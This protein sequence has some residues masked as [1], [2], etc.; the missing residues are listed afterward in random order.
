MQIRTANFVIIPIL[1]CSFAGCVSLKK[2]KESELSNKRLTSQVRELNANQERLT[3]E[4][5]AQKDRISQL[6]RSAARLRHDSASLGSE[7][8]GLKADLAD[9]N[10]LYADLMAQNK[11]LLENTSR[12]KEKLSLEIN[13]KQ[14][15]LNQKT[16][17][18]RAKE[19]ELMAKELALR[20]KSARVEELENMIRRQDSMVQALKTGITNALIGFKGDELSIELRNGK[21]Y[22]SL[23]DQLLFASGSI[24]VS[25][26][27]ED[28]LRKLAGALVSH[29]D[30]EVLIEGH[31]DN[32]PIQTD[33]MKDNWDLSV[34]RATSIVRILTGGGVRPEQI[35]AAGKGEH[36]PVSA[37]ESEDGRRLNR[38]TEI[39]LSPDLQALFNLLE[40]AR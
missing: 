21:V 36:Q 20:S 4:I 5:G 7:N 15:E 30:I 10:R 19:E 14:N 3:R 31:T 16:R 17:E 29:P 24:K 18:L 11:A 22:V 35:L 13:R 1:A 34:L 12:E 25:P 28:A 38:R 27:G 26:K 32:V 37:N 39:I 2:F 23:A 33:R 8:A 6:E 40:E 9:L